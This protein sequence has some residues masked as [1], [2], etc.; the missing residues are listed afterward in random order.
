MISGLFTNSG[1][2]N[3]TNSSIQISNSNVVI[4]YGYP[5]TSGRISK[6]NPDPED[7]CACVYLSWDFVNRTINILNCP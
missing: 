2:F 1:A 4:G 3:I 6:E 7:P 5:G